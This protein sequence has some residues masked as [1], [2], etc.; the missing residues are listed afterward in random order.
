MHEFHLLPR[1][2]QITTAKL[3]ETWVVF[4]LLVVGAGG[5]GLARHRP[6]AVIARKADLGAIVASGEWAEPHQ[7]NRHDRS[8]SLDAPVV[9]VLGGFPAARR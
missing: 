9:W 5:S 8:S 1:P 7:W 6:P 4:P 2:L 3:G